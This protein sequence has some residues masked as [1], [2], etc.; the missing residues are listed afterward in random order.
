MLNGRVKY[1][2]KNCGWKADIIWEW[3]DL[4]P[5]VCAN[6]KCGISFLA[7]PS[8]LDIKYPNFDSKENTKSSKKESNSNNEKSSYRKKT[9]RKTLQQQETKKDS[10]EYKDKSE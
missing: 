1:T 7:N 3:R 10:E 4:K 5:E 9:S 8:M 6:S 2:C